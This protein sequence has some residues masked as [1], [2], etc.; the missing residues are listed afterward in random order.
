L[1][2]VPL[3]LLSWLAILLAGWGHA[4]QRTVVRAAHAPAMAERTIASSRPRFVF[5][6]SPL[7]HAQRA[8]I[9]TTSWHP[10]V[11]SACRNCGMRGSAIGAFATGRT[12]ARWS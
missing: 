4:T 11:R 1:S 12:S 7:T 2:A 3:P 9:T 10:A 8:R 5:E 6:S